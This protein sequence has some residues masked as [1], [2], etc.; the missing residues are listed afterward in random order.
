MNRFLREPDDRR[1]ALVLLAIL[2]LG[3]LLR[4][5]GLEARGTWEDDQG[6]QVMA[7]QQW[8]ATGVAPLLGPPSSIGDVHHGV[9]T[10]WIFLPAA[11]ISDSDPVAVTALLAIIGLIGVAATWGLARTVGGVAAGHAA[12]IIAALSPTWIETS[13]FIWNANLVGPAAA[14]ALLGA[15]RAWE[16]GRTRW[17]L[18]G[19][20]AAAVLVGAHLLGTVLIPP[21]AA[22]AVADYRRR[23]GPGR[24]RLVLAL[25]GV[26]AAFTVTLVPLAIHEVTTGFAE[27]RAFLDYAAS[28]VTGTAEV[29]GAAQPLPARIGIVAWRAGSWPITGL[30]SAAPVA[31]ALV[32]AVIAVLLGWRAA[33]S[34]R[35]ERTFVRWTIGTLAFA[36]VALAIVAPSLAVIVVGLPNDHYHGF[37]D[38]L[39][40]TTVALAIAAWWRIEAAWPD[41]LAGLPARVTPGRTAAVVATSFTVLLGVP[42]I[43]PAVTPDGGWP[44]AREAAVRILDTA[45]DRPIAVVP[46]ADFKNGDAVTF[47]LVRAG[48][49][50][51]APDDGA[52]TLVL[53]CDPLFSDVVG[54]ACGGPAE[55]ERLAEMPDPT[56]GDRAWELADRFEAGSRRTISV[57]RAGG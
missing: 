12:G 41:A 29:A 8:L 50:L 42:A 53:V 11:A 5:P 31:S 10:Y 54:A 37:L 48:A 13:T 6:Q 3:A 18:V 4:L 26:L 49:T 22:L 16:T 33:V 39:V 24:R 56:A 1:D 46:V 30:V 21:L 7:V 27:A 35:P 36:I 45:G 32:T 23:V 14:V 52:V 19:G 57:Y 20:F 43:P 55:E 28:R 2:V 38:P 17:W 44:L 9:V 15:W 34:V 47:P 25:L 40:I 51:I